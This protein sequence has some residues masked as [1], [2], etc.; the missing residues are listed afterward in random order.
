MPLPLPPAPWRLARVH[1]GFLWFSGAAGL[2]RCEMST[3]TCAPTGELPPSAEVQ[4][5]GPE[6][7]FRVS[8]DDDGNVYVLLPHHEGNGEGERVASDVQRI[9]SVRW[10]VDAPEVRVQE[11]LDRTFRGRANFIAR[12]LDVALDGRLGEWEG[13]EPAVVDAPWQA[14]VREGWLGPADASFSAALAVDGDDLCVAGRLRDDRH[15]DGDAVVLSLED[16]RFTVPVA[17]DSSTSRVRREWFGWSYEAC[18]AGVASEIDDDTPVVVSYRDA[19]GQGLASV[20]ATSP[21]IGR[22]AVGRVE[23]LP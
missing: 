15:L 19:D 20:L 23:R 7:G 12:R 4:A 3:A 22:W 16:E 14:E 8:L 18:L 1:G 5:A 13:I 11:Y 17:S 10:L 2:E 9:V 21:S 6:L